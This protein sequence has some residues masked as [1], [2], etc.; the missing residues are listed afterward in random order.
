MR[1]QSRP[2]IEKAFETWF[3]DFEQALRGEEPM[4]RAVLAIPPRLLSLLFSRKRV[5]LLEALERERVPSISELA[6]RVE[7]S[8]EAVSRDLKILHKW[9]LIR[10]EQH[11]KRKEPILTTRSI[12]ILLGES[13]RGGS[14]QSHELPVSL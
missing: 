11:G 4:D 2:H 13:K 10:Y 9:G 12:V 5:E 8:V 3:Q 7:R 6:R 1:T 14:Q